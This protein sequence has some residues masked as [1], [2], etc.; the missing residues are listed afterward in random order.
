MSMPGNISRKRLK[1][2]IKRKVKK[3]S[4]KK[5]KEGHYPKQA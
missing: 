3:K 1:E 5:P 4:E 2:N